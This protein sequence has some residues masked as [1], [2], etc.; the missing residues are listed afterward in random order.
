VLLGESTTSA[1]SPIPAAA[2]ADGFSSDCEVMEVLEGDAEKEAGEAKGKERN[3]GKEEVSNYENGDE[4]EEDEDLGALSEPEELTQMQRDDAQGANI[5]EPIAIWCGKKRG[6]LALLLY[7]S[8]SRI[9]SLL[10]PRLFSLVLLPSC[11]PA[12]EGC[13]PSASWS[14]SGGLWRRRFNSTSSLT[15][16]TRI[17]RFS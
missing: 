10:K 16:Q 7:L 2:D 11:C 14:I 6:K 17:C 15:L 5:E 13:C 12:G 8:L 1:A 3:K 9:E 4:E